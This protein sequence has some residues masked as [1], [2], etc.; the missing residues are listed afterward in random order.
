MV[1]SLS[2]SL[3][4]SLSLSLSSFEV[5]SCVFRQ[6][7]G[8]DPR[9]GSLVVLRGMLSGARPPS[10]ITDLRLAR[11]VIYVL[12]LLWVGIAAYPFEMMTWFD[13]SDHELD[14]LGPGFIP[15]KLLLPPVPIS[16]AVVVDRSWGESP[17]EKKKLE[18]SWDFF[19]FLFH[20][21]GF[22]GSDVGCVFLFL[23]LLC[24]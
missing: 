22:F 3:W 9:K 14:D 24:Q 23:P 1:I 2:L 16:S 5:F 17:Q 7:L 19:V 4:L 20:N 6:G 11:S 13:R 18:T 8:G 10:R 12:L 15:P 21:H